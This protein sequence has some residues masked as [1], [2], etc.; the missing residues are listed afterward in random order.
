MHLIRL[1]AVACCVSVMVE[2]SPTS[3]IKRFAATARGY[4]TYD[5]GCDAFKQRHDD[6]FYVAMSHDELYARFAEVWPEVRSF[7]RAGQFSASAKRTPPAGDA[8]TLGGEP[9]GAREMSR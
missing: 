6:C 1:A 2:T 3:F 5:F 8:A 4:G 7:I 9:S